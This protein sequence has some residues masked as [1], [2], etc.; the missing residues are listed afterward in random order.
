MAN[1]RLGL[2][3]DG[4]ALKSSIP[5]DRTAYDVRSTS[6]G[7]SD[8]ILTSSTS[9]HRY[10]AKPIYLAARRSDAD[11]LHDNNRC[12]HYVFGDCTTQKCH[13]G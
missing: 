7:Y 6:C 11:V 9:N 1:H 10:V 12:V 4:F 8:S 2:T 3:M 5:L 13:L